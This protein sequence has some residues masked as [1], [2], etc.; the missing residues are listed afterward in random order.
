MTS[1]HEP[2][3]R[4]RPEPDVHLTIDEA[5]VTLGLLDLLQ[6]PDTADP[7]LLAL[8]DRTRGRL[9]AAISSSI[10]ELGQGVR[11]A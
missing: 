3:G 2:V 4:T 7:A 6:P 10:A 8:L 5:T 9:A 1:P 11:L